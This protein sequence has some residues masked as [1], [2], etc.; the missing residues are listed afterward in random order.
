MESNLNWLHDFMF[1]GC[2]ITR[3]DY[4]RMKDNLGNYQEW[5]SKEHLNLTCQWFLRN[6]QSHLSDSFEVIQ[7]DF[8]KIVVDFYE[9]MMKANGTING[10]EY[11]FHIHHYLVKNH[12]MLFKRFLF[13]EKNMRGKHT[14]L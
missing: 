2:M 12:T 1:N 10:A 13:F 6:P 8:V 9:S 14:G 5:L 11:A 7:S 3:H 4:K